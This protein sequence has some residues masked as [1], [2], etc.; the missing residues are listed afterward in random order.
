MIMSHE[1]VGNVKRSLKYHCTHVCSSVNDMHGPCQRLPS[2]L[3]TNYHKWTR[4]ERECHTRARNKMP[5]SINRFSKFQPNIWV[6][7]KIRYICWSN[8]V[9]EAT[10]VSHL[11]EKMLTNHRMADIFP[12][13]SNFRATWKMIESVWKINELFRFNLNLPKILQSYC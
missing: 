9:C 11:F 5:H 10:H 12:L 2:I 7:C 4:K 3:D 6:L 13:K 8:N 1:P